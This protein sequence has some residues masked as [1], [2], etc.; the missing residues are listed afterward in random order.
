MSASLQTIQ[1]NFQDYVLGAHKEQ[2][3]IAA[4]INDNFG[5]PADERLAIYYDAYRIRLAEALSEAFDKTH[6]Y[7]GDETFD[8]LCRGYIDQYPSR[9][10]NL[11]WFGDAFPAFVAQALPDYPVVA[12][13]T[14]FEWALGLAF[15]AADAPILD[16]AALQQLDAGDWEQIGFKLSPSVQ[17]LH[18]HWNAPAIWLALGKEE[19]EEP[20]PDA[21]ASATACT[22]MVWRKDLQPHFRSLD[23]YEALAL[24][25]LA[26]GFSFSSVCAEA[27]ESSEQDIT[28][29]IA[30]WLHTWLTE[31]V[32][33]DINRQAKT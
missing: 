9:Y 31:S 30:G 16:A 25:G 33:S 29:H 32:L 20:P 6:V 23:A 10:R 11:R 28:P 3:A 4:A 2:P 8:D 5:L 26:Q 1:T 24:R 22:W 15:D 12:E 18:L 13:L 14:G 17:L 21:V 27:A 19:S 7:V